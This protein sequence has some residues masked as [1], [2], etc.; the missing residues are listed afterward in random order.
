MSEQRKLTV[1]VLAAV[2]LTLAIVIVG[3][4]SLDRDQPETSQ[5]PSA[6]PT[7]AGNGEEEVE[8]DEQA[9][10]SFVSN[11]GQCHAL[12]VAGTTGEVG[13]DLDA[14]AY[15]EQRVLTAI[16]RGGRGSGQ[17]PANLIEGPEAQSVAEL[18]ASDRPGS[19]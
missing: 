3:V 10:E 1:S 2:L 19:P 9:V 6:P 4:I 5:A 8:V 13:P 7:A 17:M 18:I 12:A 15:D 16:E 14:A 11:C